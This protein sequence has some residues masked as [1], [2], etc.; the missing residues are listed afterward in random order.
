MVLLVVM[1]MEVG[2]RVVVA[3][4]TLVVGGVVAVTLV[5]ADEAALAPSWSLA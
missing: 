2:V 5:G 1:V 4:T 3:V